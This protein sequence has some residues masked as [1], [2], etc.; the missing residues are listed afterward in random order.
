MDIQVYADGWLVYGDRTLRCALG[1]G[2]VTTDK[3][4]GDK[5]TPV[6]SFPL[7]RI[8]FRPDRVDRPASDLAVAPIEPDDGWCDDPD[9]PQYNQPVKRP[10]PASHEALWRDD[11]V[12]DL[13]LV[14]GHNDSPPAP[15]AG[16]AIFL[17]VARDDFRPTEGCVALRKD[18]V[19]ALL[20]QCRPGDAIRIHADPLRRD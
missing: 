13:I 4:E 12:Y 8:L 9:D 3:R 15:G 11:H 20:A 10:Y 5:A 14:L 2:G 17:H 7:R 16:S 19:F 18:D 1:A 6:G